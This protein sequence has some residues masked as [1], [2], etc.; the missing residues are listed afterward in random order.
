MEY[1]DK[2]NGKVA[3]LAGATLGAGRGIACMLGEVLPVGWSGSMDLPKGRSV[4]EE[5][6][7]ECVVIAREVPARSNLQTID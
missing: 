6:T 5:E 1:T 2:L 7:Y 3:V 4:C